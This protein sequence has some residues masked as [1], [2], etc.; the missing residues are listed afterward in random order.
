MILF[1]RNW[2]STVPSCWPSRPRSRPRDDL[3]ILRTTR[4][5]ACSASDRWFSHLPP[6]ARVWPDVGGTTARAPGSAKAVAGGCAPCAATAAFTCSARRAGWPAVT[7]LHPGARSDHGAS[8]V[9]GDRAFARD[10]RGQRAGAGLGARAAA[11]GHGALQA[12]IS[13]GTVSSRPT[14]TPRSRH[15][16]SL[17]AILHDDA[18]Y[19]RLAGAHSPPSCPRMSSTPRGQPPGR[20]LGQVAAGHSARP[21]G[22]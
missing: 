16:R 22:L 2:Q 10:P 13:R 8:G 6:M 7:F 5:G 17:T 19:V 14:R 1:A 9:I 11:G 20:L 4:A 21:P 15:R 12:S 3:L 18:A